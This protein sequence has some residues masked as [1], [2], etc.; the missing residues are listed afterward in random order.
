ME[1]EALA[2]VWGI[3]HNHHYLFG[4]PFKVV[5]DHHA[6]CHL[7]KLK[8]PTNRLAQW[9]LKLQ[10]YDFTVEFKSGKLHTDADTLSW[11]PLPLH[12]GQE[13]HDDDAF[14]FSLFSQTDLAKA[15]GDYVDL[16]ALKNKLHDNPQALQHKHFMVLHDVLCK[17]KPTKGPS[18]L[19]SVVPPTLVGEVLHQFHND[20][21]CHLGFHKTLAQILQ[22]FYCA[23]VHSSVQEASSLDHLNETLPYFVLIYILFIDYYCFLFYLSKTCE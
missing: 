21:G 9:I 18:T 15:Q 22:S 17:I 23:G 14:L 10:E 11:D 19:L 16:R 13:T 6:L 2:I 8:N 20:K 12:E 4:H 1:L 7:M 3:K 5:T